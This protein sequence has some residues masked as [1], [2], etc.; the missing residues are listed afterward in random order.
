MRQLRSL[1]PRAWPCVSAI[2][3]KVASVAAVPSA[4]CW[5]RTSTSCSRRHGTWW[6]NPILGAT[7]CSLSVW[8]RATCLLASPGKV[9]FEVL[10]PVLA[11]P[12]D[13]H[14]GLRVGGW[15]WGPLGACPPPPSCSHRPPRAPLY[16]PTSPRVQIKNNLLSNTRELSLL[17]G[18][19]GQVSLE[20]ENPG[21]TLEVLPPR[22]DMW[23]VD[24]RFQPRLAM[25][26]CYGWPAKTTSIML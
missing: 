19:Q 5:A 12:E 10:D 26:I 14:R 3:P 8:L 25:V 6:C 18:A 24:A 13:Y 1:F 22:V 15:G 2:F 9:C 7:W 17:A 4:R 21:R 11:A 16:C 20:L 23:I